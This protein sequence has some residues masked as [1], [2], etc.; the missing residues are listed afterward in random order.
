MMAWMITETIDQGDAAPRR[1]FYFVPANTGEEALN[2]LR[3]LRP[4]LSADV[5]IVGQAPEVVF[6]W[7]EL[8]S[9]QVQQVVRLFGP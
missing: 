5:D 2:L 4:S 7:L 3:E 9:R 6:R 8:A 1:E